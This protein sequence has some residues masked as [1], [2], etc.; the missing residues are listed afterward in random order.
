MRNF[1]NLWIIEKITLLVYLFFS[2]LKLFSVIYYFFFNKSFQNEFYGILRGKVAFN[3]REVNYFQLRRNIHRIE[4][5]LLMKPRRNVF[6]KDY[7]NDT[8]TLFHLAIKVN[9]DNK[10][11]ELE[12]AFDVLTKYFKIIKDDPII[13]EAYRKFNQ[14]SYVKRC[15]SE[16]FIPYIRE[17][18]NVGIPEYES[19][20]KLALRRRSV[21]WYLNKA[22]SR[23]L[24]DKALK[25]ANLSPSACNRQPYYYRIIKNS[26]LVKKVVKI[27][28]GTGGY[29]HNIG[30]IALLIGDLSALKHDRDRH[31]IY[32]DASLS[33]M[34]FMYA[35]E[36]L[37]LSSCPINWGE[38]PKLECRI[39]KLVKLEPYER[40][41]MLISIG[42]P[43]P[44]GKVAFS[45][46][47]SLDELRR[48][49]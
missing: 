49:E 30:T 18:H 8:V 2:R 1:R 47:K 40:I 36:T 3:M 46:K 15:K 22:V 7:I 32:I 21:R 28:L 5:G 13:M 37:N 45:K 10:E 48:Y 19:L 12:W 6:A 43:D 44:S 29:E 35:L 17:N 33:A 16:L 26:E 41:I 11:E 38:N 9:E 24:I 14:I 42:F 39:R 34:A 4:K 20:L 27:P 31:L 23:D 25:I